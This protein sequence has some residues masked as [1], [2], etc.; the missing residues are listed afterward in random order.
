MTDVRTESTDVGDDRFVGLRVD[1][2]LARELEIGEGVFQS[3]VLRLLV[4]RQRCP[5]WL[6]RFLVLLVW[7]FSLLHVRTELA[8]EDVDVLAGLRMNADRIFRLHFRAVD[9]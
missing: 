8:V 2:E 1:A 6:R 4:L 3:N 9:E 7:S 5:S